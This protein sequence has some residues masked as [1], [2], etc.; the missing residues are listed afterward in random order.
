PVKKAYLN[1]ERRYKII[2]GVARGLLY[3]HQ[4]S[5][6]RIIHRDL[7]ASNILLDAEM[8]AKIADFGMARLCA[9]DQTQGATSRIVG[10]YGYMA[11]EYAMHGQFSVKSDTFSFGVL[12]LEILSGQ[13]NSAF[14]NGSNIEDL[15]S[16]AWRN[17]EAGTAFDLVDPS[18]RDGPRSEVMRCIHI[19]LLCVQEN[20]AQRPTM[21]AVVLMLTSDSTTL[22]LPLEPAFFMQSK[23]QSAMQ[24]SEDLNSGETTSSRSGNEIARKPVGLLLF[25]SKIEKTAHIN[26]REVKE[27]MQNQHNI[28]DDQEEKDFIVEIGDN[29]NYQLPPARPTPRTMYDYAKPTLIE[30]E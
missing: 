19:G 22:P 10:T 25:D 5:R 12:V 7:K 26:R 15:L 9:V 8:T 13:K 4:D 29:Q 24:L 30:V 14:H 23:T 17:W 18:L 20:V 16:F 1:W 28:V 27:A 21:G 2:G 11:P 6:L 3:L